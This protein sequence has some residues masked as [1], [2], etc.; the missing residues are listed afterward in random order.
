MNF[1]GQGFK[2][3]SFANRHID[4][5]TDSCDRMHYHARFMGLW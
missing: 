1:L 2:S 5:H 3:L 4:G